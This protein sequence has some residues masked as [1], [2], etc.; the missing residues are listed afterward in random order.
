VDDLLCFYIFGYVT[1]VA[2]ILYL[3]SIWLV[4]TDL[5][6]VFIYHSRYYYKLMPLC[7]PYNSK[8]Y[9]GYYPCSRFSDNCYFHADWWTREINGCYCYNKWCCNWF[10]SQGMHV[11]Q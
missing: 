9:C 1:Y 7:K 5:N 4:S 8:V 10:T 11:K 6:F 3:K 2:Y